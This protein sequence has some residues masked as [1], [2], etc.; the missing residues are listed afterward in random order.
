[1]PERSPDMRGEV[2]IIDTKDLITK[3]HVLR[4]KI[5]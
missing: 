3:N 4:K 2:K 5:K 1:M